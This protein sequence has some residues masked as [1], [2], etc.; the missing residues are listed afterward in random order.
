MY[1]NVKVSQVED[2]C[3]SIG[4]SQVCYKSLKCFKNCIVIS[5]TDSAV[6]F[7]HSE[8]RR[9]IIKGGALLRT[10]EMSSNCLSRDYFVEIL[11]IEWCSDP[12]VSIFLVP[13]TKIN[14]DLK[15][16]S[17]ANKHLR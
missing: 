2:F 1:H 4:P 10:Q 16:Q 7:R 8:V 5:D 11:C 17:V 9:R 13:F 14:G 3:H 6:C 15:I 12:K